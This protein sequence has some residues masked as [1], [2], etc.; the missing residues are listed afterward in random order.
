MHINY[1]LISIVSAILFVYISNIEA[2][3]FREQNEYQQSKL[4]KFKKRGIMKFNK[5][6]FGP[7]AIVTGASSGI[8]K[9][10]AKQLA[11]QGLNVVLIARRENL[12][13]QISTE[14][15]RTYNVKCRVVVCDLSDPNFI[16]VVQ[17]KTNDLDVGLMISNAGTGQMGA[18]TQVDS[19]LLKSELNVNVMAQMEMS[20][21]FSNRLLSKKRPGGLVLLSSTT[22]FQGVPMA[23]N[24]SAAKAY[25]LNLG[26]S[27]NQEL[28][29][30]GIHVSVLV[31]GPTDTPGLNDVR[32]GVDLAK[33]MPMKPMTVEACV[34]EGLKA[35]NKNKPSH[36]SGRMNRFQAFMSK[37]V[38]SRKVNSTMWGVLLKKAIPEHL[39]VPN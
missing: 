30:R 17:E 35:L 36:V 14:L 28:K 20:H 37:R 13:N 8:G 23:G 1:D 29:H 33:V 19:E 3:I 21:Y 12:L 15:Q 24:Y 27:L 31:P 18:F 22:A 25:I 6:Q 7:W 32:D 11:E 4:N 16:D 38:M 34:R 10:F 2:Q 9:Q 26:E 39:I 5:E